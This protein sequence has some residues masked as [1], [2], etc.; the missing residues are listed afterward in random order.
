MSAN[1]V[2]NEAAS[3][4]RTERTCSGSVY[5]ANDVLACTVEATVCPVQPY[6]LHC[7]T[8][9]KSTA[10]CQHVRTHKPKLN[11]LGWKCVFYCRIPALFWRCG[12]G[13]GYITTNMLKCTVTSLTDCL[14]IFVF[15]SH[16]LIRP[17]GGCVWLELLV[18]S[19]VCSHGWRGCSQIYNQQH[20]LKLHYRHCTVK[21]LLLRSALSESTAWIFI[22]ESPEVHGGVGL[23]SPATP[24]LPDNE[25]ISTF[26]VTFALSVVVRGQWRPSR[27]L[28][29]MFSISGDPAAAA[30][31]IHS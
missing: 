26:A 12:V 6:P 11:K 20:K 24:Q 25:R 10:V 17:G 23:T 1:K 14:W 7:S 31:F 22:L 4:S 29:H 28:I 16:P 13:D 2:N 30:G 8:L 5:T 27:E 9:H 21:R 19:R 15:H 18:L 3:V